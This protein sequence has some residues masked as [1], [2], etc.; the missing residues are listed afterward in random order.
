[1]RACPFL[2]GGQI[3]TRVRQQLRQGRRFANSNAK[4][5]GGIDRRVKWRDKRVG[6]LSIMMHN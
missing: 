6:F 5:E 1:M 4:T 3:A 2:G